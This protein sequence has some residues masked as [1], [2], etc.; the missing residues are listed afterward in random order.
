MK[1]SGDTLTRQL[2]EAVLPA[3]RESTYESVVANCAPGFVR[4]GGGYSVSSGSATGYTVRVNTAFAGD[5]WFAEYYGA[6]GNELRVKVVCIEAVPIEFAVRLEY[7]DFPV[8]AQTTQ[9]RSVRCNGGN[10]VVVGGGWSVRSF[11]P[12]RHVVVKSQP[13]YTRTI[14]HHWKLGV[15]SDYDDALGPFVVRAFAVCLKAS[16]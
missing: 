16:Y 13:A 8:P 15:Y 3:T 9:T 4:T 7:T 10:E 5:G 6:G 1:V 11:D 14:G 12:N 2:V